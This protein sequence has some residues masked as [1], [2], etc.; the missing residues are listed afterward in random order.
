MVVIN[1]WEEL[2]HKVVNYVKN[3]LLVIRLIN[4]LLVFTVMLD[5]Y[6]INNKMAAKTVLK[7][8]TLVR[9]LINVNFV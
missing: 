8:H 7:V 4:L 6:Q 3:V 2:I 1:A 9:N 5:K